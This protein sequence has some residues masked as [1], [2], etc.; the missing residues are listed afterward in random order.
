MKYLNSDGLRTVL[1]KIKDK[2]ATKQELQDVE[3]KV[4]GGDEE[5]IVR[6]DLQNNSQDQRY[7]KLV[8]TGRRVDVFQVEP[9]GSYAYS[10]PVKYQSNKLTFIGMTYKYERTYRNTFF[11]ETDSFSGLFVD[12]SMCLKPNV[13]DANNAHVGFADRYVEQVYIGSYIAKE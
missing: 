10:L 13:M 4:G 1:S 3:K 11:E 6:V 12:T 9:P 8:K 5:V 2:F 7:F